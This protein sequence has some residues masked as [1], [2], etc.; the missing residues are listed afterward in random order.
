MR[1]SMRSMRAASPSRSPSSGSSSPTSSPG[2]TSSAKSPTGSGKTLAFSIPM[3]DRIEADGPRPAALVLAPTRELA[4]QIVEE[5]RA[6]AHARALRITAVYGGVGL[7]KQAK[8]AARSHILVA[9]PGRL[10]DLLQRRAFDLRQV[11]LLVL[12]EADRML[13]MGF[14]PA[15]DRIVAQCPRD[16]QTLFFSAT[17]DGEAGRVAAAFTHQRGPPRARP[18][19]SSRAV[20]EVE[21]RF[22]EVERDGKIDALISR[23]A[24]RSRPGARLRA[25]QARRRPPRQAARQSRGVEAVAMHGDKSQGQREKALARFEAG[26]STRWSRPTSPRA[27]STS[28]ASRTSSTST[29]PATA[30]PTSTASDAPAAPGR[31]GS[32]S[33][34]SALDERH[35]MSA[36]AGELGIEHRLSPGPRGNG[37]PTRPAPRSG[38]RSSNGHAAKARSSNGRSVQRAVVQRAVVQRAGLEGALVRTVGARSQPA[39]GVALGV[40]PAR[41]PTRHTRSRA[42]R[43]PGRSPGRRR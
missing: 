24:R 25:H 8:D 14:K 20:A 9:T 11:R 35:E 29:P 12:D 33:R 1:W 7:T 19:A 31:P 42:A 2:A 21:H 5:T 34:S 26:T 41:L 6:I 13:D 27:A 40:S 10:E 16:R 37:S 18:E 38:G 22:L 32:A 43:R 30:T 4:S 28:A 23:A 39:V 15:V 3:V 17:L 36:L